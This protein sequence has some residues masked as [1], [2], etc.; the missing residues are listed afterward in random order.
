MFRIP[1][2]N[3]K[4]HTIIVSAKQKS[5]FSAKTKRYPYRNQRSELHFGSAQQN[6]QLSTDG[7]K[8]KSNSIPAVISDFDG[9][10][11]VPDFVLVFSLDRQFVLAGKT[12]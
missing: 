7:R 6:L 8:V 2:Q 11:D 12:G 3:V 1:Q 10:T 4:R 5:N 9:E